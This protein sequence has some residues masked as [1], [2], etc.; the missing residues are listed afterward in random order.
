MDPCT[1]WEAATGG[2]PIRAV[3]SLAADVLLCLGLA[4]Q[5]GFIVVN[6]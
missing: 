4:D 3:G 2:F 5:S 6:N 1:G